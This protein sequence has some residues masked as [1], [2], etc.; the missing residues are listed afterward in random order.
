MCTEY[1]RSK[2]VTVILWRSLLIVFATSVLCPTAFSHAQYL[3]LD[4][5]AD[6][7]R[8]VTDRLKA[9]GI[10]T[11]DL[12]IQTAANRDGSRAACLSK[13]PLPVS[14]FSYEFI[15]HASGG[16]IEWGP[17]KNYLPT[18]N[19]TFG[20]LKSA[21]DFYTG[22][23]VE[24]PLPPGK[25]KLGTLSVRVLSGSPTIQLASKA[26]LWHWVGT[27]FGSRNP[28][29]D[30]DNTIKF[31]ENASE[32]GSPIADV[33]GDWGDADGV[34]V[35]TVA[36]VTKSPSLRFEVSV[37]PNP[38][39]P[40]AAVTVSTTRVGFLRVRLFDVSGR[41]VRT[42]ADERAS[43][44]GRHTF[45]TSSVETAGGGLASGI[46]FYTVE[47]GE[48]RLYGRMVVLK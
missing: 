6:G 24:T 45:R 7:H 44:V 12:W 14:I 38:L 31:T 13:D 19:F 29:K 37:A 10:T 26:P 28:G 11:V 4:T 2:E 20:E 33:P 30:G 40:D 16:T 9:S 18:A 21:T 1:R 3:F 46:Y 15:L 48:G 17:Y 32:L 42:L 23:A 5:N 35:G 36:L 22:Y 47:A 43:P 41:L 34:G 27:S 25:H 8:D 39:N